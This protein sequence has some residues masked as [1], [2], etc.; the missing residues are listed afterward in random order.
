M[1]EHFDPSEQETKELLPKNKSD[2][3]DYT[4]DTNADPEGAEQRSVKANVV[5]AD[6]WHRKFALSDHGQPTYKP[7]VVQAI[8]DIF[9]KKFGT[10]MTFK[11]I[12]LPND[13]MMTI[14][15]QQETF[16]AH[17]QRI[18]DGTR[19]ELGVDPET[20]GLSLLGRCTKTWSE[21]ASITHEYFDTVQNL[22]SQED[23]PD[24]VYEREAKM[25]DLG[26]K[27]RL[28]T[29]ALKAVDQE[30]GNL[31]NVSIQR[32]RV[33]SQVM[34]RQQRLAEYNFKKQ[35]DTSGKTI[36]KL[37]A[38]TVAHMESIVNDA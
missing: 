3:S 23:L 37:N 21:F 11:E 4:E 30:F 26:R 14:E 15:Q 16:Q 5:I 35:A 22:A 27:A 31:K 29:D 28:L 34:D 9:D 10:A 32:D 18:V 17:V 8:M 25:F 12:K 33:E 6:W 19:I 24:W 38:E 7:E 2:M 13:E 20:T 36:R 1:S